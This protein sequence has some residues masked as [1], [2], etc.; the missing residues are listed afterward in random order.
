MEG[1]NTTWPGMPNTT[2]VD[3]QKYE[4][5]VNSQRKPIIVEEIFL[6][7]GK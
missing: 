6:D 4:E 7:V 5:I 2:F 3:S 1:W